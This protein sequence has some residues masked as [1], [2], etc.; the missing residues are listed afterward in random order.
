[1]DPLADTSLSSFHRLARALLHE[2]ADAEDV[3]Q[4]AWLAF[5]QSPNRPGAPGE[6]RPW[7]AGVVRR[8]AWNRRR[9]TARRRL[10]EALAPSPI[11]DPGPGETVSRLELARSV[12]DAVQSLEEP[13]R[14]AMV[15]HYLE[16]RRVREVARR[17]DVSV[18]TVRKR[19]R[20]GLTLLRQRLDARHGTDR[21]SFLGGLV[22]LGGP[23]PGPIPAALA[24]SGARPWG[25]LPVAGVAA[26]VTAIGAVGWMLRVPSGAVGAPSESAV[27]ATEPTRAVAPAP[28]GDGLVETRRVDGS[29]GAGSEADARVALPSQA[30]PRDAASAVGRALSLTL[31]FVDENGVPA[32]VLPLER[33]PTKDGMIGRRTTLRVTDD[34]GES[35]RIRRRSSSECALFDLD[36]GTY[37]LLL[38]APGW[39]PS[40]DAVLVPV[41][42]AAV[43]HEVVVRRETEVRIRVVD[44]AGRAVP[45]PEEDGGSLV[46]VATRREF[47]DGELGA[48]PGYG[49][50]VVGSFVPNDGALP[51]EVLGV[52]G[53][54]EEPP[55]VVSLLYRRRQLDRTRLDVPVPE[56]EFRIDPSALEQEQVTGTIRL[57]E[58]ETGAPLQGSVE[59]AYSA[60]STR[61]GT[62]EDGQ[63]LFTAPPPGRAWIEGWAHGCGRV[64]RALQIPSS[65]SFDLTLELSP[66]VPLRVRVVPPP[67]AKQGLLL[68]RS[69]DRLEDPPSSWEEPVNDFDRDVE[70]ELGPGAWVIRAIGM[71][72]RFAWS[73]EARLFGPADRPRGLE[74]RGARTTQLVFEPEDLDPVNLLVR[75]G[76]G[77]P[78]MFH[79]VTGLPVDVPLLPGE[80]EL[81]LVEDGEPMRVFVPR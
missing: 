11:P 50:V 45:I 55:V 25:L 81:E 63:A 33:E 6:L 30:E 69:L 71:G 42:D 26:T 78:L 64:G 3:V 32:D 43:A 68:V 10:R 24:R 40:A 14:T 15:L 58:A 67:G 20:R 79:G 19:V 46:A 41:P 7:F 60:L 73:T 12:L 38:D 66:V 36:P 65:G 76:E 28:V 70:L 77:I 23:A 35:Q 39:R 9:E 47:E 16:A 31:R 61:M 21:A 56:V 34:G 13:V 29:A 2:P 80:Y 5:L 1:M 72:G 75:D 53:L 17:T 52:L 18:E 27:R 8:I 62:S 22:A 74:L 48:A 57:V 51:P 54:R 49:P 4:D 44:L 37:R 59:L